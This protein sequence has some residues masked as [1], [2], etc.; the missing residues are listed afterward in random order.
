MAARETASHN[1]DNERD[2]ERST[3]SMRTKRS[4]TSWP[5]HHVAISLTASDLGRSFRYC[6]AAFSSA[7]PGRLS[8][9]W[10]KARRRPLMA[11][12]SRLVYPQLTHPEFTALHAVM[13]WI[14]VSCR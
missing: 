1:R 2:I 3:A 12:T 8:G 7:A 9:A 6:S 14:S 13:T 11:Q 10:S 4:H 5:T